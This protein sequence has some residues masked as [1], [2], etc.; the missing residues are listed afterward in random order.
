MNA[1]KEWHKKIINEYTNALSKE[2]LKDL[3]YDL[4][5]DDM[6]KILLAV[7]LTGNNHLAGKMIGMSGRT[8]FRKLAN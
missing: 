3:I 4:L 2:E 5:T 1:S 6:E 7:E 8:I